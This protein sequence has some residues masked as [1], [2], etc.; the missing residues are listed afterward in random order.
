M[1]ESTAAYQIGHLARRTG[2]SV[3]AIRHYSDVG[4]LPPAGRSAGGYRL[5]GHEHVV[6]LDAIRSL[7]AIGI[8]LPTIRRLLEG[9]VTLARVA[10]LQLH[11]IKIQLRS[12]HIQRVILQRAVDAGS[13]ATVTMLDRWHSLARLDRSERQHFLDEHL[14]GV[15][16][17]AS[18][19][20]SAARRWWRTICEALPEEFS[21]QQANAWLDLAEL[22]A[23]DGFVAGIERQLRSKAKEPDA[24]T[25]R[26]M[27]RRMTTVFARAAEAARRGTRSDGARAREIA[28]EFVA[29][30]AKR[31][32]KTPDQVFARWLLVHV[33]TSYDERIDRFWQL[34]ATLRGSHPQH[35][36]GEGYRWL[37]AAL[38]ASCGRR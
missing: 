10:E 37:I 35:H 11:A 12:L 3:K 4:V 26:M 29:L 5:Y 9:R 27:S 23:D 21:D 38:R 15:L 18:R 25:A 16:G 28:Q 22:V 7:R 1:G 33:E 34:M 31:M 8:D 32:H 19:N 13:H 30:Q 20:D 6:R 24:R 2:V 17:R 14:R 36:A